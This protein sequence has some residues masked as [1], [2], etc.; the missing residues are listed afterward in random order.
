LSRVDYGV[1]GFTVL[2]G[3]HSYCAREESS[4]KVRGHF[5]QEPRDL[6]PPKMPSRLRGLDIWFS[7]LLD[8]AELALI[9]LSGAGV[10]QFHRP[11]WFASVGSH[12]AG[13]LA[14]NS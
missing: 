2:N 13:D 7:G 3:T 9:W 8:F 6:A 4:S 14:R 10:L 1:G 11:F 12:L 5:A